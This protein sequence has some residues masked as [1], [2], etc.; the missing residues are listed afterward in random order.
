MDLNK[1]RAKTKVNVTTVLTQ[2]KTKTKQINKF[3]S[4]IIIFP[5]CLKKKFKYKNIFNRIYLLNLCCIFFVNPKLRH[6][7]LL[8]DSLTVRC[9]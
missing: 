4:I 7:P 8:N 5:F 1:T 9:L 3:Y 6:N 2:W